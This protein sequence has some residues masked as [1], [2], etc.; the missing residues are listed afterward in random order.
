MTPWLDVGNLDA[1]TLQSL[2]VS[3]YTRVFIHVIL[4]VEEQALYQWQRGGP[5]S[6]STLAVPPE[7]R[8]PSFWDYRNDPDLLRDPD[9]WCDREIERFFAER[10]TKV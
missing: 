6:K 3:K 2:S 9:S 1:L 8:G 10:R 7:D 4:G 5:W